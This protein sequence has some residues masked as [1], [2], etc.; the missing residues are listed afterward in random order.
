MTTAIVLAAG[1]SERMG[2]GVDKAFLSL[3]DKPVVAWSLLAFERCRD[4][5]S[6]VLVVRKDKLEASK[7]AAKVYG[8]SKMRQIVTGGSRRQDSVKAGLAACDIA[9]KVV[10]IHD[11]ARPCVTP[12][13]ISQAVDAARKGEC[14]TVGRKMT[15]TVKAVGKNGLVAQTESRDG[16]WT[17]QTPQAFP[18]AVLRD[19]YSKIGKK[20][21][22]DDCQ[23]VEMASVPV[24]IVESRRPNVKITTVEDLQTASLLLK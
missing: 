6:I 24:R 15:D 17:V 3:L 13:I 9:T 12:E 19:A 21:V 11:G 18:A 5:D 1:K 23:A 22:T 10:V 7:M 14:V 16:L 4:I 20:E 8:I 2:S